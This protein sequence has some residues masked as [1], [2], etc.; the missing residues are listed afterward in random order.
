MQNKYIKLCIPSSKSLASSSSDEKHPFCINLD[1]PLG[2]EKDEIDAL[3]KGL[4][5]LL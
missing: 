4:D 5:L 1:T 2:I 3:R